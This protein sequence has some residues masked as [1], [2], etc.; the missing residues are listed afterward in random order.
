MDIKADFGGKHKI[1]SNFDMSNLHSHLNEI[2]L[3][4]IFIEEDIL[5]LFVDDEDSEN[6]MEEGKKRNSLK[7]KNYFMSKNKFIIKVLKMVVAK[8]GCSPLVKAL[9][10]YELFFY[11]L[12]L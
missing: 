7:S 8:I 6:E 12:G 10:W 1:N 3:R 4:E 2:N 9:E 11:F 5:K